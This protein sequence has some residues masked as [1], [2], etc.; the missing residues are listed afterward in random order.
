MN[1]ATDLFK[2]ERNESRRVHPVASLSVNFLYAVCYEILRM[3]RQYLRGAPLRNL[4]HSNM[5]LHHSSPCLFRFT[6][7]ETA[8]QQLFPPT[9]E[10]FLPLTHPQSGSIMESQHLE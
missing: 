7:V 1:E 6:N 3:R 5:A 8:A 4:A 10:N 9:D 2:T